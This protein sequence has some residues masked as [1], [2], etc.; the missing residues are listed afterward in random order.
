M[1]FAAA[2][3]RK[4]SVAHRLIIR[5]G[6]VGL[7]LALLM[8][9]GLILADYHITTQ[10]AEERF[11]QIEA[12][13]LA[14]VTENVWL[15][16]AERLAQLVTGIRQFPYVQL[17][18]VTD[19][20]GAVLAEEGGREDSDE[21]TASYPL[22]RNY[23]GRDLDIGRL[24]VSVSK[25]RMLTPVIHRAGLLFLANI[26][27]MAGILATLYWQVYRLIAQPLARIAAHVRHMNLD[28]ADWEMPL[29]AP[30]DE[31]KDLAAAYAEM[32]HAIERGYHAVQSREEHLRILFDNSP[33]SLWE[34]DFSRVKTELE[35]LRGQVV[36]GMEAYLDS[37]P[38]VVDRCAA[39]VVVVNV[40]AATLALHNAP[41]RAALLGNLEKTFTP[42]SRQAF[43]RQIMAIWN[44][45]T[46]LSVEGEVKT[47]DGDPRTVVVHWRVPP[48]HEERLDRVLVALENIT[49]RK[50]A[51]R[52]LAASVDKLMRTNRELERM[53]E[54]TAHDL[55][56]PVRGIVSFSQLLERRVGRTLD[57][58]THELLDYLAK[59]GR[60]MQEQIHG[61][62]TYAQTAPLDGRIGPTP[63]DAPLRLA[64]KGLADQIGRGGA[65]V[66]VGPLPRVMGDPQLLADLFT[67][68]IDNGLK[69]TRAESRPRIEITATTGDGMVTVAVADHGIGILPSYAGDVFQVFRRL[70]GPDQ[71]P[72]IGIGLAICR[73]IV[74]RLGGRI[75]IDTS[76]TEG[77]TI[78]FTLPEAP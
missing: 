10:R 1:T 25:S 35:S 54:I 11:R 67:R 21:L 19:E 8:A 74:E 70:H 37:H 68:L 55:Q 28:K 65:S 64:L 5:L 78:R 2:L 16:D 72:G 27:L 41:N 53:T 14:S 13:Y 75:W 77:C 40:N 51:E 7:V 26:V 30:H 73:K 23:S 3:A 42:T 6:V 46:Q 49:D 62:L 24:D 39:Q 31:L 71:F 56:E 76:V 4:G 61:L 66:E 58:D 36:G 57:A 9:V 33:V 45:E 47:L 15:Q 48:G 38:D 44:G 34:E 59:A 52:A 69:F 60:R 17:V 32:R 20:G 50:T 29:D 12:G 43:A 18:R 22:T 63:L